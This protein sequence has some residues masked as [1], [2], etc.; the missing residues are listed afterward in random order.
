MLYCNHQISVGETSV[1]SVLKKMIPVVLVLIALSLLPACEKSDN[2]QQEN[3]TTEVTEIYESVDVTTETASVVQENISETH[4]YFPDTKQEPDT[5]QA[6]LSE[7]EIIKLF[8][9]ANN[10]YDGWI[11]HGF[12]PELDKNESITVD[13]NTF[14]PIISGEFN[15][16]DALENELKKYF[17]EELYIDHLNGYYTM[18]NEKMY[19]LENLGEGGDYLAQSVALTINSISENECKFTVT[20]YLPEME[21]GSDD[22]TIRLIDG[23]WIFVESFIENMGLYYRNDIP[24]VEKRS[25]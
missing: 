13:G 11:V 24:W 6:I 20:S 23:N 2:I 22:Y 1:K 8:I 10:L 19:G 7:E 12:A 5:K 16:V 4:A 9:R 25:P 17:A 14:C 3:D 15:S 21:I 18:H